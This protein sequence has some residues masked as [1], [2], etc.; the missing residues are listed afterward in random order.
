MIRIKTTDPRILG[1]LLVTLASVLLLGD[2]L[3]HVRFVDGDW[4]TFFEAA[5]H[6]EGST[7]AFRLFE[8]SSAWMSGAIGV[9]LVSLG[10]PRRA[11]S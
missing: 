3:T 11:T 10:I 2:S 7:T 5:L 1:G 8:L 9:A 4:R 6:M